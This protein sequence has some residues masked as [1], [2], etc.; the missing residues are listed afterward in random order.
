MGYD[1]AGQYDRSARYTGKVYFVPGDTLVG[2]RQAREL[3]ITGE[4]DLFGSV[5]PFPFVATKA[6][7]HPLVDPQACAPEGWSG[8]FARQVRRGVLTGYSAFSV[9][10][11]QVAGRLLLQHGRVRFKPVQATAGRGQK[12]IRSEAELAEV[13]L[14]V[15]PVT[16]RDTGLVLEEDLSDVSTYSVGQV[17]VADLTASYYGTQRLTT[18]N[19]GDEVYGGSDLVVVRGDFNALLE[20][21]LS[22]GIRMAVGQALTY[23]AATNHF[24]GMFASRRNY[25]VAQGFDA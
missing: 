25:D 15:D 21:D 13:L 10:D 1:Y 4:P 9:R 24:P 20:L 2:I 6:I 23:D 22:E 8:A 7:S 5:V 17:R 14:G 19:A 18:D 16:L 3:G 11:A 12:V